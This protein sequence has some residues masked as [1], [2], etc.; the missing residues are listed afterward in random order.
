[1]ARLPFVA[2]EDADEIARGVFEGFAAE[3]RQPIALYR[4]L[5]NSP[6]M[7]RSYSTLA[8]SL[9]YEAEVPRPLRELL[10]LRT[11]QL[12]GSDYEWAHHRAMA[13]KAG[14]ADEQLAALS[15]WRTS[16]VYDSRE[17]A[18]L[19]LVEQMH[20]VAVTD[21]VFAALRAE[22]SAS[23]VIELLLTAAF[24]QAVARLI[25]GLGLEVEPEYQP[26]LTVP[27]ADPA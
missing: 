27:G 26:F 1:M 12:I 6:R 9:R 7:L 25:D 13:A 19:A 18:V 24:Y 3:G 10:I 5:A 2:D 11:A 20:D 8:R 22:F 4:V 16:P 17:R 23:E 14:I 15:D 21:E